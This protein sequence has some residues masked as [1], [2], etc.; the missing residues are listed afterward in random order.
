MENETASIDITEGNLTSGTDQNVPLAFVIIR[1]VVFSLLTVVVLGSNVF[2][3]VV[4]HRMPGLMNEATRIFMT[5]LTIA[6]ICFGLFGLFPL[7][8]IS[9]IGGLQNHLELCLTHSTLLTAFQYCDLAFVLLINGERYIACV[10]P[11]RYPVLVTRKRCLVAVLLSCVFLVMWAL[12]VYTIIF[13]RSRSGSQSGYSRS[14]DILYGYCALYSGEDINV[15]WLVSGLL[16]NL[17]L[18]LGLVIAMYWRLMGVVKDHEERMAIDLGRYNSGGMNP[19]RS[20]NHRGV[21]TF[22]LVTLSIGVGWFPYV[23]VVIYQTLTDNELPVELVFFSQCILYS[24][25][26]VNVL[27]YYMR[28]KQFKITAKKMFRKILA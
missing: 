25:T 10:Y 21:I 16:L 24:I 9:S 6:D 28:N 4:I 14:Y 2:A 18:P 17:C 3:L 11:L 20:S 12:C 1:S 13:S 5:S 23:I 8:V 26:W 22:L 7:V 19:D 15:P 27:I